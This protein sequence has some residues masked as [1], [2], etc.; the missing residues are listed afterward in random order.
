MFKKLSAAI[1]ASVCCLGNPALATPHDYN[2]YQQLTDKAQL[3]WRD[4]DG[5]TTM[6]TKLKH[7]GYV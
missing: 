3:R 6:W 5:A 4:C 1:A 7:L 2:D